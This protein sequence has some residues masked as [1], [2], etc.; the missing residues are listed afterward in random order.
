MVR[1]WVVRFSASIVSA[2]TVAFMGSVLLM[3]AASATQQPTKDN[4]AINNNVEDGV[5]LPDEGDGQTRSALLNNTVDDI[6]AR[7]R[8]RFLLI[9]GAFAAAV[10]L[11]AVALAYGV[12]TYKKYHQW[13]RIDFLRRATREFEN[14]P[15][16]AKAL[17]ILDFEE[18]RDYPLNT[19]QT[20]ES[21]DSSFRVTSELL[22][23]ALSSS[24]ARRK[25][26]EK[27]ERSA[28]EADIEQSEI[29][30]Y[31]AETAVRDWFNQ[32]L[33]GLEHFGY[34]VDSKVFGVREVKPW[35]NYW[36]RLIAD[37]TYRRN[38]DSRV[39]DKLYNYV[40]DHG[41]DGVKSL[42][43]KFGYRIVR[44]PYN[45]EDFRRLGDVSQ[46]DTK[47][48]LSLAKASRLIYQDMRYVTEISDLWGIDIRR[49][50]RYF[51]NKQRDTQA[52]IFR[53]DDCMVLSFRGSQEI[54]DWY[55]NFNTQLRNFTIRKAGKTK[56]S[57]YKGSVQTGFF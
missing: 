57:S 14:D 48:A 37:E 29:Q 11:S 6:E 53:T 2:S 3:G 36:V 30:D 1:F 39:Y 10:G 12:V 25:R 31:Y 4:L 49:N 5:M 33:N 7:Q 34:L 44:S 13:Q 47:L 32:M 40:Y 35:L 16:I 26:K 24:K 19:S 8:K 28:S 42:F 15:G 22:N 55:T 23:K 56:L 17:S 38:R 21:A 9:Q 27:I 50:F 45:K 20:R 41:F 46:Y 43:E 54:R 51:N 18:Y 52:F